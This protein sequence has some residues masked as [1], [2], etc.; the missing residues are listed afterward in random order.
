MASLSSVFSET[1]QEITT[2]KLDELSK[3]RESYE[4]AKAAVLLAAQAESDPVRR[5]LTLSGGVKKAFGI[6][7][8]KQ[9]PVIR[10]QTKHGGLEVE[11]KNLDRFLAQAKYDPS[12]STKMLGDWEASLRRHLDMLSLKYQYASLYGELVTEWLSG[13]TAGEPGDGAD[14]EMGEAF[15]D[16]GDAMKIESRRAWEKVVFEPASVDVEGLQKY[17]ADLF[18]VGAKTGGKDAVF[19]A[20]KQ[21]R[22]Q[23]DQFEA[24][25]ARPNLFSEYNL[26][27]TINGLL[28]SDLLS[29]EK[30]QVLRDFSGNAT[31]LG[32]IADV[33]NMR[34][35]ALDSWTWG[36]GVNLEQRRKI[37]G[38]Y[39]IHMHEDL[40]QAIFLQFVGVQWSVFL[41]R[42]LKQFRSHRGAWKSLRTEIPRHDK[43]RLGYYLGPVEKKGSLQTIRRSLHRKNYFMSQL[44]NSDHEQYRADQGDVEAEYQ[45]VQTASMYQQSAMMAAQQLQL[46]Q[47]QQRAMPATVQGPAMARTAY[48]PGAAPRDRDRD[49]TVQR[50]RA[51][52]N[53]K[54]KRA[55]AD[56]SE[57]DGSDYYDEDDEDDVTAVS[58]APMKLKQ[59][60]LHLL[61][62]E[63]AINTKLHGQLTAFHSVFEQWNP[64]LPHETILTVLKFLG[65]SATWRGFFQRFLAAPLR[66]MDDDESTP[67]RTRRR[68]TPGS[69]TL[70][71]VF[72][73]AVLFCLDFAVNQSVSGKLLWRVY[74][75][76][77]FW[78]PDHA[79]AVKAW[80]TV[81]DFA[82][83]TGTSVNLGKTGTVRVA[84]DASVSLDI[85]PS[86]PAG[87]IRWGFLHLSP[88]SGRFEIDQA[89]VDAHVVDLRKQLRPGQS[90]IFNF[91]QTW[92]SYASTFFTSNFG[93][94]ANCFGRAHVDAMLSAHQRIQHEIFSPDNNQRQQQ[95]HGGDSNNSGGGGGGETTSVVGYLK[96]T[97]LGRFGISDVPDGYLFFPAER[98]G[99]ALQSPF[100]PLLHLRESVLQSPAEPLA[101]LDR[102]ERK[103]YER[104]KTAFDSGDTRG[105]GLDEPDWTPVAPEDRAVFMPFDEFVR[106]REEL[107]LSDFQP[108]GESA[109]V[110]DAFRVLMRK[111]QPE[112][113]EPDTSPVMAAVTALSP[114]AAKGIFSNWHAMTPYWK[115]VAMMYG[116]EIIE[117]FGG[118]DVVD[119]GLLPMGMVSFFR[120]RRIT[121]QG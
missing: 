111:P 73:E 105:Y 55:E 72:G 96:T 65:V 66:F 22:N 107:N 82:K 81:T 41:K 40:L 54:R 13:D 69:H 120:E 8:D 80:A 83:A 6:R 98:G 77:W 30:R 93:H 67:P 101:A 38:I 116:P 74:D 57:T 19:E 59:R 3:R 108:S 42:A 87:Q 92:N 29:D 4:T 56:N 28:S 7:A 24:T 31:I 10:G 53:M 21:L 2:I 88:R 37:S 102:W 110:Q 23:V 84:D 85:D 36:A 60:L 118:L 1:L 12:V 91:I 103:A 113:I 75:D 117:R 68:G 99:L 46:Q 64:L 115:W 33:L 45:T 20:L 18:G 119:P 100:I 44:M 63:I 25:L 89:M 35:A 71:D 76:I 121:W 5:L 86:L 62:T 90:S 112:V 106:Y 47:L 34:I 52:T 49:M 79:L 61:S 26:R 109:Q 50:S 94:V 70:S 97:L 95:Q 58:K 39:N 9:G 32:E 15:E 51:V 48:R 14:T 78:S 27:S 114:E 104:A 16:V 43:N 11:L 17:L